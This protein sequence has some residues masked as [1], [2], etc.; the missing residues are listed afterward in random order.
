MNLVA[1]DWPVPTPQWRGPRRQLL[2]M[3]A[4]FGL[5][6]GL[7]CNRAASWHGRAGSQEMSPEQQPAPAQLCPSCPLSTKGQRMSWLPQPTEDLAGEA[8]RLSMASCFSSLLCPA[9]PCSGHVCGDH[10]T[11][12]ICTL[13]A[14]LALPTPFSRLWSVNWGLHPHT[15]GSSHLLSHSR[16]HR[17]GGSEEPT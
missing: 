5:F 8:V 17:V 11:V 14:L 13:A 10:S 4:P 12:P 6:L 2:T 7:L 1:C 15:A 3:S 9:L 16:P